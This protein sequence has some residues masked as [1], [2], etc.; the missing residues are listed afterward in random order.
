MLLGPFRCGTLKRVYDLYIYQHKRSKDCLENLRKIEKIIYL[1]GISFA[2][3]GYLIE[4]CKNVRTILLPFAFAGT[5]VHTT[6]KNE[7]GK[8]KT[9]S[10]F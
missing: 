3:L 5:G 1:R 7:T 6:V 9:G 8:L 2:Y 4:K 10:M